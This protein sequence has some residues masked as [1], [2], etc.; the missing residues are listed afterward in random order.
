[1]V[2]TH[3]NLEDEHPVALLLRKLGERSLDFIEHFDISSEW[4]QKYAT[5]VLLGMSNRKLDYAERHHII[6]VSFY[7]KNGYTGNRWGASITLNNLSSLSFGE[8][9]YAHYLAVKCSNPKYVGGCAAAFWKLYT[10]NSKSSGVLPE[11]LEVIS[12]IGE[13]DAMR[14]R[15]MISSVATVTERGGTHS[16]EDIK[17]YRR[18]WADIN[19]ERL[20]QKRHSYYIENREDFLY[21]SSIYH[22]NNPEVHLK[23]S[24]KYSESHRVELNKKSNVFYHENKELCKQRNKASYE[25]HKDSRRAAAKKY[26]EEHREH[27]LEYNRQYY[28]EHREERLSY[29]REY[30]K[31]NPEKAK[32]KSKKYKDA[33]VAAGY[34]WRMDKILGKRTWVFV[35]VPRVA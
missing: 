30:N 31:R 16:W 22:K 34:R 9:V 6:P 8:H 24:R 17:Q 27:R 23:A 12:R 13:L 11:D 5:L 7:R 18:E 1:M 33:K 10:C 19:A 15:S 25:K 28:V 14:I 4:C 2:E 21:K 32:A 20:K 29:N 35:G 26:R 3:F